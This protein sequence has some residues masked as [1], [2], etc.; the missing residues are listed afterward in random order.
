ML[1]HRTGDGSPV[2][3]GQGFRG[4]GPGDKAE[5]RGARGTRPGGRE[6]GEGRRESG[7]FVS[8]GPCIRAAPPLGLPLLSGCV[9]RPVFRLASRVEPGFPANIQVR[10]ITRMRV[11]TGPCR[12][13]REFRRCVRPSGGLAPVSP[14]RGNGAKGFSGYAAHTRR[15][16]TP[17]SPPIPV[18]RHLTPACPSLPPSRPF[19]DL[20]PGPVPWLPFPRPPL[21]PMGRTAYPSWQKVR[22][23]SA[24]LPESREAPKRLP[25]VRRPLPHRRQRAA[26][27]SPTPLPWRNPPPSRSRFRG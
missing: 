11:R 6:P 14:P 23:P 7:A 22:L 27:P 19:P 17:S 21:S 9:C 5:G 20:S 25:R 13:A 12:G 16:P 26:C 10:S 2:R 8:H 15:S 24:T 3:H 18:E 4:Q 1:C